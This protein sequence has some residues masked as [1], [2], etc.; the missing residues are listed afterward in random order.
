MAISANTVFEVRGGGSDNNGGGFVTGASG[1]DFSQQDAAQYALTTVTTAA[2][3]A[4]C[5][6]ASA[7]ADMVGNICQIISGTNFTPG[8][9]Q[10]ISVSV[11]VSFTLDR[12]CTS[13]A[14]SLGVINI[15]GAFASPGKAAPA[16]SVAGNLIWVK[17]GTY[18]IT[19]SSAGAGGPVLFA[20]GIH[21][22]MEG[23][24]TTRGDRGGRPI[25]SAGAVTSVTLFV[26]AGSGRQQFVHLK[27]DGN[28]QASV[29]GFTASTNNARQSAIDCEAVNCVTGFVNTT[30][31]PGAVACKA[32]ACTT[33]FTGA[34]A[35]CWADACTTGFS[36]NAVSVVQCLASDCTGD[37]FSV[38][39]NAVT[40]VGCTAEGNGGDGF[41]GVSS[42][43]V[44]I[45][46]ASTN[47]AGYGYNLSSG[48]G[49]LE[50]C[51]SYNNTSGR[52][53][54]S[55]VDREPITLSGDPWEAAASDD[56][57]PDNT[58]SEGAALRNLVKVGGSSGQDATGDIGAVHHNDPAGGG[59]SKG[60]LTGLLG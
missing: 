45:A 58:A 23:Y 12:T 36:G 27:A 41:D 48:V 8:L 18:T 16:A 56:Y 15:G 43:I 25:L 5:L 38:S 19:T 7:A 10:I 14:G 40:L 53:N 29:N 21:V 51:A 20:S 9:Y 28:S 55:Y 35:L 32:S 4:I 54:G 52:S 31:T 6:D 44:C 26:P 33:G 49:F 13:A 17:A 24:T 30:N 50:A 57:A 1:T 37:G 22:V 42:I 3:N 47:N 34:A 39:G 60:K 46:C 59:A 2:A 11:G